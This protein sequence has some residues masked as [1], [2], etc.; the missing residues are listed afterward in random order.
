MSSGL[1]S[2]RANAV[3]LNWMAFKFFSFDLMNLVER[4]KHKLMKQK[5]N[6]K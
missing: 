5:N 6:V 4:A 2:G 1:C 3:G